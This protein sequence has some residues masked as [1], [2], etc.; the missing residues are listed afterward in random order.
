MLNELG[1]LRVQLSALGQRI[2]A[3]RASL[4]VRES[5]EGLDHQ[6]RRVRLALGESMDLV[7]REVRLGGGGH[8]LALVY[9]EGLV[10]QTLVGEQILRPLM[11]A[12]PELAALQAGTGQD[13]LDLLRTRVL[14]AAD[15]QREPDADAALG[16]LFG[17]NTLVL[18]DGTSGAL[19]CETAGYPMRAVEEPTS[20]SGVR[21]PREGFTESLQVNLSL[22]RRR[23]RS[24]DLWIEGM[25]IG[26]VTG[27]RVAFAYV[28]GTADDA[29]VAEA[30]RRLRR[31]DIDGV[32]ESGYLEEFIEDQP[33]SPFPQTLRTERPD[34]VAANLLEGRVAIFT[35][36]TPFVLVAPVVLTQLLGVSE[37]YYERFLI[38]SALRFLRYV[39][40]V[41]SMALP[42]VYI[43]V[44]TFHQEMLPTSLLLSV[45]AAREG[46]PFPAIVEAM[47]IELM[48]EML[49]EAGVRLPRV[50]GPAISIV[51]ALVLGQAAI[52]ASLVSP[53]MAVVVAIT[54]I[55]SFSTPVFSLAVS[56]RLL[57]FAFMIAAAALGL[58]GVM[59]VGIAVLLHLAA[60][61]SF[62]VPYLSPL[63][64][65]VV[66]DWK[67]M[68]VRAPWWAM[69][70]RPRT[71]GSPNR[72]RRPPGEPARVF[73]PRRRE[74]PRAAAEERG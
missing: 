67:D 70:K 62:G 16:R 13:L 35:D 24:P 44:T 40:F 4:T 27:T 15:V 33:Y 22:L 42:S 73:R 64:P 19:I 57:R 60:L 55:A 12:A 25:Q 28:R 51:G 20:E 17:G 39:A 2:E 10:D 50:V 41:G 74:V 9:L 38:G 29:L 72:W 30:R 47:L 5:S 18:A 61:R 66:Q 31:I 23:I 69:K 7:V 26:R 37:D 58:F 32:L 49:R 6:L 1:V 71:V 48:F 65:L 21:V 36:N 52:N 59:T 14:A 8:R 68:V 56:A 53:A 11:E 3:V 46:V 45:A 43:A 63:G 54:A 34:V